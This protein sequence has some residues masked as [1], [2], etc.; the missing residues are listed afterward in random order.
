MAA[1]GYRNTDDEVTPGAYYYMVRG[2]RVETNP[3]GSYYNASEGVFANVNVV[4]LP[5]SISLGINLQPGGFTLCWNSLPGMTYRVLASASLSPPNWTNVSG[6][7]LA[8]G[9][10]T[11][12]SVSTVLSNSPCFY[13]IASP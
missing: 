4:A 1:S 12:W 11:A 2:V 5:A 10:T 13:E 9:S 3:S 8:T 7:I 6:A